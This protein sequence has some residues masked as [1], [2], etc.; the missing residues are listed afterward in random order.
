MYLFE[1]I[2]NL[3]KT[4]NLG[5]LMFIKTYGFLIK[6]IFTVVSS[7]YLGRNQNFKC[8][9]DDFEE[10]TAMRLK[11]PHSETHHSFHTSPLV[12][13]L[14]ESASLWFLKCNF[15][16]NIYQR[17]AAHI[18]YFKTLIKKNIA[19]HLPHVI[20]VTLHETVFEANYRI[21]GCTVN[22]HLWSQVG[23]IEEEKGR[24]YHQAKAIQ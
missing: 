14:R 12:E 11:D 23:A 18:C 13:L 16:A 6:L 19:S 22:R 2:F 15:G 4:W 5:G 10:L 17:V 20:Y 21:L 8:V 1:N 3:H 24:K 7:L 9:A